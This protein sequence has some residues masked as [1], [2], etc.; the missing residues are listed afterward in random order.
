MSAILDAIKAFFEKTKGILL[1]LL[2]PVVL[3]V[4]YFLKQH[5]KITELEED[6]AVSEADKDLA[7]T[8]EKV[9]IEVSDANKEITSYQSARDAFVKQYGSS[10][11]KSRP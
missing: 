7:K 1:Y 8:L 5:N 2:T 11:P 3:L 4:L 10:D 9:N 6:K